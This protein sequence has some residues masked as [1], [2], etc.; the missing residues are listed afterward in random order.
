[1]NTFLEN[2]IFIALIISIEALFATTFIY[3][4]KSSKI[5]TIIDR[6]MD[7]PETDEWTD[8]KPFG[9]YLFWKRLFDIIMSVSALIIF[10][11]IFLYTFLLL[12]LLGIKPIL[13]TRRI[14]GHKGK[15]VKVY[16]FNTRR[17]P[18][19]KVF[20]D[21]CRPIN[22]LRLDR[23][24]MYF[25]VLKGDLSIVG[26]ENIR[27]DA[28]GTE[29]RRLKE[30]QYYRPGMVSLSNIY[31]EQSAATEFNKKYIANAG[32]KLDIAIML[33]VVKNVWKSID[34]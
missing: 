3:A 30:Y 16:R 27:Y 11:P 28:E 25:S 2:M 7:A 21:I 32:V 1:M 20:N 22:Q 5:A 29:N 19:A 8:R 6:V 9:M 31:Q 24:P 15:I 4:I 13:I 18:E 10:S 26:L 34:D 14:I 12:K 33:Y 17:R 23:F